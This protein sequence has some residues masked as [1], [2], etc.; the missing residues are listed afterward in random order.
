MPQEIE[1]YISSCK[2]FMFE[3]SKRYRVSFPIIPSL[4]PP[5]Y[6][7]P[8]MGHFTRSA[9][10]PRVEVPILTSVSSCSSSD[11]PTRT[12]VRQEACIMDPVR[13]QTRPRGRFMSLELHLP[14]PR[15]KVTQ[16]QRHSFR[17][18]TPWEHVSIKPQTPS[19]YAYMRYSCGS[20]PT[21]R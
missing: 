8:S 12:P 2:I 13:P 9:M 15:V 21:R 17:S 20:P 1:S 18:E 5:S 14:R 10:F 7:A 6:P 11:D 4:Y 16:R 3:C 19:D